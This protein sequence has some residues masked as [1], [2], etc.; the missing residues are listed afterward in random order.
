MKTKLLLSLSGIL[1]LMFS[2]CLPAGEDVNPDD[3]VAKFLGTWRVSETCTRMNYNVEITSDPGNSS[4]V[5][6]YNFGNPGAGYD[7]AVGLV[8]TNTIYVSSQNIGEGWTV[9]GQGTY[10]SNGTISWNYD[11]SIPPVDYSCTA[12]FSK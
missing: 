7:P 4:Q 1:I 8:V 3:P 10:L 5:F 11:L 6:I 9:N 12:T 2:S